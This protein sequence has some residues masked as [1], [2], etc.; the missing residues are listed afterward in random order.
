MIGRKFSGTGKSGLFAVG[1]CHRAIEYINVVTPQRVASLRI[2]LPLHL[3]PHFDTI[4]F[5]RMSSCPRPH[6]TVHSTRYSAGVSGA[7]T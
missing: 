6:F 1:V 2:T 7:F 5:M 3:P 4:N